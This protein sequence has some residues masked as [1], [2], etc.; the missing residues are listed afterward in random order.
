[1]N[2]I[3]LDVR[4]N[5]NIKPLFLKA[6]WTDISTQYSFLHAIA[7]TFNITDHNGWYNVSAS[8]FKKHG[9]SALLA[10]YSNSP[11]KLLCTLFPEY[12][13]TRLLPTKT[14][15]TYLITVLTLPYIAGI[16]QNFGR[17][18][19]IGKTPPISAL[20]WMLLQRN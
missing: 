19:D 9:G 18:E 2:R 3:P 7:K 6:N 8:S 14:K 5:S 20:S 10:K 15:S 12:L 1:M 17:K 16:I 13:C 4:P 11:S